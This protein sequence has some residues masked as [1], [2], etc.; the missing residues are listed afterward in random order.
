MH[1][2]PS[3]SAWAVRLRAAAADVEAVAR[4]LS[5]AGQEVGLRGAPGAALQHLLADVAGEVRSLG[6]AC[7]RAAV[8]EQGAQEAAQQAAQQAAQ[9]L[10]EGRA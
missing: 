8:A 9:R 1:P 4:E 10:A 2:I 7:E 6:A 5:R 3:T